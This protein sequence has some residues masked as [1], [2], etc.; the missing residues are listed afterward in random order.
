MKVVNTNNFRTPLPSNKE[1]R[2]LFVIPSRINSDGVING[3]TVSSIGGSYVQGANDHLPSL[4]SVPKTLITSGMIYE[5]PVV[6]SSA[7]SYEL[8]RS[9]WRLDKKFASLRFVHRYLSYLSCFERCL[10][11]L[12]NVRRNVIEICCLWCL[13][14]LLT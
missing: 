1:N 7:S 6:S 9:V 11:R 2:G 8:R 14:W 12:K 13:S 10:A 5:T 3:E 4:S